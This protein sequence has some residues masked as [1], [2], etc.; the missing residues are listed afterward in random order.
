MRVPLRE[1]GI[2]QD[3][4]SNFVD[5]DSAHSGTQTAEPAPGLT[6]TWDA[7]DGSDDIGVLWEWTLARDSLGGSSGMCRTRHGAMEALSKAL[8]AS[9]RPRCGSVGPVKLR[10]DVLREQDC[11][12]RLPVEHTAVYERGAIQWT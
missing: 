9:G 1:W 12:E 11:Y 7:Q 5:A 3:T 2:T 4:R 6:M 8:I 10:I